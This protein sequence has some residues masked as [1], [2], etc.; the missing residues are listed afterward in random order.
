MAVLISKATGN[1]TTAGTWGVVDSTSYLNPNTGINVATPPSAP[2]ASA[3]SA[4]F[5][6]GAIQIDAI[7]VKMYTFGGFSPDVSFTVNLYNVTGAADVAGTSVTVNI[8]DFNSNAKHNISGNP[9]GWLVFKLAA[10]VTLSAATQY[11]VQCISSDGQSVSLLTG[12]TTNDWCRMLRTTTTKAPNSGSPDTPDDMVVSGEYTG[13]GTSNS[14]TVTMDNT[15]SSIDYGTDTTSV[16]TA[17]LAICSKGTL[18][19]GTTAATNYYLKISGWVIVYAGGTLNIGTTGTPMPRDSTAVLELDNNSGN[20]AMSLV[21]W[22][23]G[24]FNAQGQSRTSGK[25]VPWALLTADASA[26][27]TTLNVDRDTGWLSGDRVIVSPAVSYNLFDDL[28]L[29]AN[30]GASSITVRSSVGSPDIGTANIHLGTNSPLIDEVINLTRNVKIRSSSSTNTIALHF[31]DGSVV[32]IDWVEFQYLDDMRVYLGRVTTYAV[33]FSMQFSSLYNCSAYGCYWTVGTNTVNFPITNLV[34]S[35]NVG[36]MPGA[37]RWFFIDAPFVPTNWTVD[38]NASIAGSFYIGDLGGTCTNNRV[39][40]MGG[41]GFTLQSNSVYEA[42]GTISNL[43]SHA[44]A[45]NGFAIQNMQG[46][47]SFSN[48]TAFHCLYGIYTSGSG[49]LT[50]DTAAIAG[51]TSGIYSNSSTT[52]YKNVTIGGT[53]YNTCANGYYASY[54]AHDLLENCTISVVSGVYTAC[55]YDTYFTYA[56]ST[57]RNCTLAGANE[58]YPGVI[59]SLNS[60]LRMEKVDG[61]AGNHKTFMQTGSAVTD[62]TIYRSYAPSIRLALVSGRSALSTLK[63]ESAPRRHGILVPVTSGMALTA[64]C[65]V[66]MSTAGDGTAYDGSGPRLVVRSNPAVGIMGD[67]VLAT[68]PIVGASPDI[69]GTWRQLIGTTQRATDDGVMEFI[70]DCD[71]TA[72]WVNIDD[73][74]FAEVTRS[75][76]RGP[77]DALA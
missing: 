42:Y 67:M 73:F 31:Y 46:T 62:A 6:P 36:H 64:S 2:G 20:R 35:N 57:F 77:G 11:A 27:A 29:T 37:D 32:D 19:F 3:R 71:G 4:S 65:W 66:R 39:S 43:Y 23:G 24:T 33:N 26:G 63:L 70:V 7:A 15:N 75:D 5:T 10:P 30:A 16:D 50:I 9:G 47:G 28:T 8:S 21:V 58:V 25:N 74:Q 49:V 53:S 38:S 44:N 13:P 40:G 48:L 55:T 34:F 51:C 41:N 18:S 52:T 17:S 76:Y 1:W 60:S 68:V 59:S 56:V 69:S 22:E 12:P 61:I 14:Y 72:G 54:T 45:S